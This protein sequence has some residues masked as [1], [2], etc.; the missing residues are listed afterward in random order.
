MIDAYAERWALITG[1]SS[2][3]GKKFA[4][5]LA[6]RG[7]HLVL[8][9]RRQDLMRQLADDLF[10]RHGTKCEII[11]TDLSKPGQ[12]K[13]LV[14]EIGSRNITIELLVNSAG[15]AVVADIESID[16]DRVQQMLQLNVSALTDLTYRLLPGMLERRHGAIIN[17]ASLAGFQPVAY[18][19]SYAA[20]KAYVLHF[21]E[22]LWSE[23]RDYGVTVMALCPGVTRTPFFEVAEVPAWLKKRR[24]QDPEVV[25]RKALKALEKRRQYIVPG[26][27]N[28]L[29]S[30]AVRLGSRKTVVTES[31]KY[32]R[33]KRKKNK[34]DD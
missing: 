34:P 31:M 18:M 9:A 22:A 33:P 24:A 13:Q 32:F 26:W 20:S 10:T 15:F 7:M 2:G 25:V 4:Q 5:K 21:S 23:A 17:I 3:I 6:S 30:L 8:A 14:D 27:K 28:Y 16:A 11:E 1:A 29:T 12:A 19:G